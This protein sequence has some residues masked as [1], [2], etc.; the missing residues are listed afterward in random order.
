MTSSIYS[1][2][3]PF[4]AVLST[5]RPIHSNFP[6]IRTWLLI[7]YIFHDSGHAI[8][9]MMS[10]HFAKHQLSSG[11]SWPTGAKIAWSHLHSESCVR[12][13]AKPAD[14]FISGRYIATIAF[15]KYNVFELQPVLQWQISPKLVATK[16][17]NIKCGGMSKLQ[18]ALRILYVLTSHVDFGTSHRHHHLHFTPAKH[19]P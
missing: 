3:G 15:K 5:H 7:A 1:D 17:S 11:L 18:V 9:P 16:C 8:Q 19:P 4:H 13:V 14:N 6:Y 10:R 2:I 12:R